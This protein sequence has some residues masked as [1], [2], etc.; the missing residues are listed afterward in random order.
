MRILCEK[1]GV[2]QAPNS[3]DHGADLLRT[4]FLG[5]PNALLVGF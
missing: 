4:A 2:P 5:K 3:F 1:L